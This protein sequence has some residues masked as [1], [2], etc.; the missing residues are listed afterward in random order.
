MSKQDAPRGKEQP[1]IEGVS[2]F[3]VDKRKALYPLRIG[4][5][6][7]QIS[8]D[9]L[10]RALEDGQFTSQAA[11][12]AEDSAQRA[13]AG[14]PRRRRSGISPSPVAIWG[15]TR[16]CPC[17]CCAPAAAASGLTETAD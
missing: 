16:S 12:S 11:L 14:R 4:A 2:A 6:G 1:P 7:D 8:L 5:A 3:I 10:E 17:V 13:P 15:K 9:A